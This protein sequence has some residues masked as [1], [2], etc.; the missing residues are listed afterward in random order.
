MLI[1]CDV[2]SV[3][4]DLFRNQT[5][6]LTITEATYLA[7]MDAIRSVASKYYSAPDLN[8]DIA[9]AIGSQHALT[10]L[11]ASPTWSEHFQPVNEYDKLSEQG[12][13]GKLH[14]FPVVSDLFQHPSSRF[15]P[16]GISV[17]AVLEKP[18]NAKKSVD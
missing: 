11:T 7:V 2:N 9:I 3:S 14:G 17:Y 16:D 15:M 1:S 18:Y 4:A 12:L 10:A 5:P 8:M 6:L 13:W